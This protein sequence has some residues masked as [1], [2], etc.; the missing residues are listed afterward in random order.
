[1]FQKIPTQEKLLKHR[2]EE[3]RKKAR[4]GQA[5]RQQIQ[6]L[7]DENERKKF[8]IIHSRMNEVKY[9]KKTFICEVCHTEFK[10]L[11][12]KKTKEYY[13]CSDEC[14]YSVV[15]KAMNDAKEEKRG[16]P[17]GTPPQYRVLIVRDLKQINYLKEF[18]SKDE[19][20]SFYE[21]AIEENKNII[22]PKKYF[23]GV[24]KES[25]ILLLKVNDGTYNTSKFPNSYG[26]LVDHIVTTQPSK[27]AKIQKPEREWII[28]NKYPYNTE[29]LFNVSGIQ[30]KM[31]ISKILTEILMK[32][33]IHMEISVYKNMLLVR[34][35]LKILYTVEPTRGEKITDL[36]NKL[37]EI[38][39]KQA[40]G[41]ILFMGRA[42]GKITGEY[43]QKMLKENGIFIK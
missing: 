1:M 8:M 34:N 20:I 28:F 22:I 29:Q 40:A 11:P 24:F 39:K 41:N 15:I 6:K 2:L 5:T 36:Y 18:I 23:R 35:G 10:R 30:E 21:K 42:D 13:Y 9:R 26:K 14:K 37:E 25:E 17:F 4:K 33:N 16:Y 32:N 27:N 31:D 12:T 43:T 38:C 3:I 7:P 19:A